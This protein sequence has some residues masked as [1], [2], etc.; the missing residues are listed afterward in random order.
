MPKKFYDIIPP[1]KEPVSGKKETE[2]KPRKP[3]G[4][5]LKSLVFSVLGLVL[6]ALIGFF[7]F[8]DIEVEIWPQKESLDFDY[9]VV[10]GEG[11][12]GD[13]EQWLETGVLPMEKVEAEKTKEKTFS[14]TG[15]EVKESRAEG[16]ITVYNAHS[17]Y[18]QALVANT[19]FVSSEGKLFRTKKREV[20]KGGR[21]EGGEFVPGQTDIEV[22]A[23]E[24]GEDYN[25]G[26]STFSIPAW[27]GTEKYTTFYGKSFSDMT[28]GFKGETATVSQEDLEKAESEVVSELKEESI[29][30]LEETLSES[31]LLLPGSLSQEVLKKEFSREVG[32]AGESFSCKAEMKSRGLAV[33]REDMRSFAVLLI[34]SMVSE[35]M[36]VLEESLDLDFSLESLDEEKGE[37][38]LN[39][40]V[41]A[42]VFKDIDLEKVKKSIAGQSLNEA[43]LF[44]GRLSG[45][46]KIE[47]KSWPF[48]RRSL[49]ENIEEINLNL[50]LDR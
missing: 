27:A 35:E 43:K 20:I 12:G 36:K 6:I 41:K 8:S 40:T 45:I 10:L 38:S 16:V 29:R 13:S 11:A 3:K 32:E 5:F 18:N 26:P 4:V 47:V 49:P 21:Y 42:L 17:T 19:R 23:A 22:R 14:S 25:I 7:F 15:Q 31:H 46:E 24:A 33:D 28:G 30:F 37:A 1:N 39:L 48:W 9:R 50:R 44:L 34:K 2:E